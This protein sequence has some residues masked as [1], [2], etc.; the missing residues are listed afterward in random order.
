MT[1]HKK[2]INAYGRADEAP[3][4]I[5][6]ESVSAVANCQKNTTLYSRT[7]VSLR[8]QPHLDPERQAEMGLKARVPS[9]FE[10]VV[11]EVVDVFE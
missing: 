10:I 3:R 8:E 6:D 11:D 1:Y 9:M 5:D 2:T 4:S 7:K